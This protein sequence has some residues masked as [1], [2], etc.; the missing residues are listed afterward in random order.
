MIAKLSRVVRS[1]AFV[2]ASCAAVASA[3][4]AVP[5]GSDPVLPRASAAPLEAELEAPFL[6]QA[7]NRA[8]K[9]G[10]GS[11]EHF[12][13]NEF[14]ATLV[15][16]HTDEHVLLDRRSPEQARFDALLSDRVT[17]AK[18]ALDPR[19]LGLLRSLAERHGAPS[20]PPRIELVSGYRSP[21]LNEILRKK[22]H[23]VASHSQHSKG[24]AVDFRIIPIVHGEPAPKAID[25][26][27][28]EKE[29]R[30]L[31]WDG[32]VGVYPTQGDWFVHADVGPNRNWVN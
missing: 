28:L 25:P 32:G 31:G 9:K 5:V 19:L 7:V 2:A 10:E 20:S 15:Q 6:P 24:H 4:V 18:H 11:D 29:I 22:G 12:G 1:H 30:A 26:R 23:H 13:K 16:V 17:G 21:K 8:T 14:L 27:V 3:A